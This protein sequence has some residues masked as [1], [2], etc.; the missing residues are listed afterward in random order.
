MHSLARSSPPLFTT[1]QALITLARAR[2]PVIGSNYSFKAIST[3]SPK[4]A[5]KPS[6]STYVNWHYWIAPPPDL[7]EVQSVVHAFASLFYNL[8]SWVPTSVRSMAHPTVAATLVALPLL[9]QLFMSLLLGQQIVPICASEGNA[10]KVIIC[11]R[12]VGFG[13]ALCE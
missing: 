2:L 7:A 8:P 10:W 6:T 4:N 3:V 11:A 13:A 9:L 1:Q 12:T 5:S